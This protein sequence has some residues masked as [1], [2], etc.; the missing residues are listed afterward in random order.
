MVLPA[1]ETGQLMGT[2]CR[3]AEAALMWLLSMK[4]VSDQLIFS[5][6]AEK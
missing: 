1:S 4:C 6:Q 3:L 5:Q 2:N